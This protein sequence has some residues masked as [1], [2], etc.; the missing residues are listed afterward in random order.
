M[1]RALRVA[2]GKETVVNTIYLGSWNRT[3]S[4]R[5]L[6]A[7]HYKVTLSPGGAQQSPPAQ[8]VEADVAAG[9]TSHVSFQLK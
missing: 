6:P 4:L 9:E 5:A 8:E 2:D 7:G 1:A 3:Q